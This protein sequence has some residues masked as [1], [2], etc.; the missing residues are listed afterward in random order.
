MQRKITPLSELR[1]MNTLYNVHV[2]VSRTWEYR[3]KKDRS[4][5]NCFALHL[6]LRFNEFHPNI[7]SSLFHV[8]LFCTTN[9]GYAIYCEVTPHVLDQFKQYLQEG[10][11]LYICNT[12]VESA[13]PGYRV[14]DAPYML[15]FIMRTQIF[16]GNS[17]ETSIP[18]YVFSL[19]P[20][21]MLP[22]YARRTDRFLDVI[23]K[24][25]AISNAA[26]A[27]NTSGDLMMRRLITLQDHNVPNK[28]I[29]CLIS[30]KYL[31]GKHNSSRHSNICG[32]TH[33]NISRRSQILQWY[34]S[35]LP[36]LVT[37]IKKLELQSE[38]Y[39]EQGVEE[40][41]LFDLKQ[42]DPLSD[43]NKRFQCTVTLISIPEKEQW[44]YRACKVCNS[45]MIPG[46]DGYQ[47]TK[48]DGCSSRNMIGSNKIFPYKICFIG[49]DDTYSL[50]FMFFEKKGVELIGKSA[51]TL[52]KQHDPTS[53][54]PEISQW[55][56]HK[57]TF[58]VKV[59][60]KKSIQNMEPSFEATL[61]NI[62]QN[63][64]NDDLPPLVTISSKRKIEQI[65]NIWMSTSSLSKNIFSTIM[66]TY[67]ISPF[68]II[69]QLIIVLGISQ[70]SMKNRTRRR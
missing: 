13:K 8:F 12:C 11:V 49:A 6:C 60:F 38:D 37:P 62:I 15:K 32:H 68:L 48:I 4:D 45:R 67:P 50:Q 51:E 65:Y 43:K 54:P 24:I 27:R 26:V 52:R 14:V 3:G 69:F 53:I 59:L 9:K 29:P 21:E 25:T 16:E 10:K 1:P 22:Q 36:S 47:C 30:L 31:Q 39:M 35:I 40:K 46:D 42:I 41:T 18:K 64:S 17:N 66:H 23:G 58:I 34:F 5:S 2:R 61:P 33:E 57:F 70:R 19:T 44:C 20:I 56:T 28:K 7:S 63:V 55:I